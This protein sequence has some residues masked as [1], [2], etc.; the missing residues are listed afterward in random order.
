MKFL[1]LSCFF[2]SNCQALWLII[3]VRLK[4]V[5]FTFVLHDYI[6]VSLGMLSCGLIEILCLLSSEVDSG[7]KCI[8][9]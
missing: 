5:Y 7:L 3:S 6:K 8:N 9:A 1:I 2:Y 4:D